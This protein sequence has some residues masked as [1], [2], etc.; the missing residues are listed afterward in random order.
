MLTRCLFGY[1]DEDHIALVEEQDS[2]NLGPWMLLRQTCLKD[3]T[4]Y[5][6]AL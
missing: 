5:W 6:S 1:E 4:F 3:L 2:G